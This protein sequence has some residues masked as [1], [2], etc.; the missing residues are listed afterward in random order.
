MKAL[1]YLRDRL[2][3]PGTM[4][5]LVWV[6]LGVAGLD[7]GDGAVTHYALIATVMLGVASALL[8]ERK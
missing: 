1:L 5:S 4:R 3:E 2:A 7:R 6:C 8:P